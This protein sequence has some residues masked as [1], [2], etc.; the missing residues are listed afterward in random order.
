M[1]DHCANEADREP[2]LL[3]IGAGSAGFSAAITAAQL[4][5]RV[6]IA[7]EGVI[8][9]TCVNVGCVPSK[10]LIR[11]LATVHDANAATRFDGIE[12]GASVV[13]WKAL[14]AQKQALVEHLRRAKYE[15]LLP[16][17][18]GIT[19]VEGRAQFT[20][21]ATEVTVGE[22]VY[23]P[24]KVVIAT[25]A[26]AALPPINGIHGVPLLDSTRALELDDLPESLLV[27]GGGVIGCELAQLFA[28]AGVRVTLCC[29]SRLLPEGEPEVSEAL[30]ACL[31]R[32]GVTIRQGM[33]YE[34]VARD[35]PGVRLTGFEG[36]ERVT[37][38]A[39]RVL[40]ATGRVPT[41]RHLHLVQAG[42]GLNGRGGIRVDGFM[43]TTCPSIYAA[44]DVTGREMFVYMAAYGGKLAA[45]N[46]LEGNRERYDS[47]VMPAVVFTEPQVAT[48]GLSEA[49]A[50]AHGIDVVTSLVTLDQVPRFIAARETEGL[51]KLVADRRTDRLLGGTVFGREAGDVIQTVVMA[52]KAGMTTAA[53]GET[54]F[55]YLTAVEGLKLAAQGFRNDL[56]KLSCCAG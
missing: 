56:A 22:T 44:G 36:G 23:R 14:L 31:R 29:R 20:G 33:R 19:L 21:Q 45:R 47:T 25:G 53:L 32:E 4:G 2:D 43:Q 37:L 8:G 48:V 52:L 51:I 26:Q 35:E 12:S 39:E 27:I 6:V 9:G 34:A 1:A 7:G 38:E 30:A 5:A 15:D 49:A 10:T 40:V 11:A 3:V 17:Y 13:D 16:E 50:R 46:A 41:T 24:R 54:L 28:R 18:P 55:P 42:I